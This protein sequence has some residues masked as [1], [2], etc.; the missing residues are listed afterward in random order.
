MID[1]AGQLV[2][3]LQHT[4]PAA[5]RAAPDYNSALSKTSVKPVVGTAGAMD[6]NAKGLHQVNICGILRMRVNSCC[7]IY[8]TNGSPAHEQ[9]SQQHLSLA[10]HSI[11]INQLPTQASVRPCAVGANE[12]IFR[13]P[14]LITGSRGF[15]TSRAQLVSYRLSFSHRDHL[16]AQCEVLV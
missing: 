3:I 2:R 10:H 12:L 15:S 16:M 14:A 9:S 11:A 7:Q 4:E 6:A 1:N 13:I 8:I 5:Y